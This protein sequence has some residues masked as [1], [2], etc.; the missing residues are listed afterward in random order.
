MKK[1]ITILKIWSIV[2]WGIYFVSS[3]YKWELY[4]PFWWVLELP[5]NQEIRQ[6]VLMILIFISLIMGAL[7]NVFLDEN[8][9]IYK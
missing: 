3:F 1:C 8:G 4:N 2:Y 9:K 6:H 5:N 7:W